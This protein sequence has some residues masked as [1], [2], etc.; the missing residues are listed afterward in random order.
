MFGGEQLVKS[1]GIN[2]TFPLEL[3]VNWGLKLVPLIN[4]GRSRLSNNLSE[5]DPH[6]ES[7]NQGLF[8]SSGTH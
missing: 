8:E 2:L 4:P 6:T 5:Y 3:K 1:P 7:S